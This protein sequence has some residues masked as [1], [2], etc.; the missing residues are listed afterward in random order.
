MRIFLILIFFNLCIASAQVIFSISPKISQ[1]TWAVPIEIE[2]HFSE[3][4]SIEYS[5]Q[6]FNIN[7]PFNHY[8]WYSYRLG[9]R[10]YVNTESFVRYNKDYLAIVIGRNYNPVGNGKISS[11]FFIDCF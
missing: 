9:E 4:I 5:G 8:I 3:S 2:T 7:H 10:T 1:S 6:L 11:L